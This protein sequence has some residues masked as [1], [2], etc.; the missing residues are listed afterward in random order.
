[1]SVSR[2]KNLSES[3]PAVPAS[4]TL[5]RRRLKRFASE[6]GA[7]GEQLDAISLASSE[8]LTN[9][10]LHA[11]RDR[12]DGRID[13]VA[14]VAGEELWVLIADEGLGL[15]PR[16]DSP[17]LGMG[18][19]MIA[20]ITDG[21]ELVTRSCGGTE[22]R[23]R[24]SLRSSSLPPTHSRGSVDSASSPPSSRFSTTV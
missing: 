7:S 8:A 9:V 14:A 15:R 5:A 16:S 21:M 13:M 22:L 11:Y 1:M 2:A 6:A 12:P 4:V 19:A 20:A 17:G 23:M 24:F 18:L 10:V 3:Y